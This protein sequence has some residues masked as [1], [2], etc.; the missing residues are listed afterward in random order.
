M[1]GCNDLISKKE[2]TKIELRVGKITGIHDIGK[3]FLLRISVGLIDDE[4]E[5]VADLKKG[6]TIQELIGQECLIITNVKPT[7]TN[8]YP[9]EAKILIAIHE[10]KPVL[11][12]PQKHCVPG[13]KVKTN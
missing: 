3:Q 9:D 2:L 4:F 10:G 1:E 12:Q 5:L 6:Y 7:T 8:G 13:V 11:I